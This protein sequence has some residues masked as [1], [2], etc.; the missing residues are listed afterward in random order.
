MATAVAMPGYDPRIGEINQRAAYGQATLEDVTY[1]LSQLARAYV[2]L[3]RVPE[4]YEQLHAPNA[5]G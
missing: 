2:M 5:K 3:Y 1:L 4:L